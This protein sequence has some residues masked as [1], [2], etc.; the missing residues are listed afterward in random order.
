MSTSTKKNS[1]VGARRSTTV[2]RNTT[3]PVP[4]R[5]EIIARL[6]RVEGQVRG[7]ARMLEEGRDC[8]EVITQLAAVKKAFDSAAMCAVVALATGCAAGGNTD[9]L[10]ND[11]LRKLAQSLA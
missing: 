3:V 8:R 10:T 5:E 2:A 6:S 9:T 11:E 1:S 4:E 7:V